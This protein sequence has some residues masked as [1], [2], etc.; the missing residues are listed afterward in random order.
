MTPTGAGA[1]PERDRSQLLTPADL[2][3][4]EAI[5]TADEAWMMMRDLLASGHAAETL[6]GLAE[7]EM[8]EFW[9][10][11]DGL[12]VTLTP[13]GKHRRSVEIRERVGFGR[14][15]AM[16]AGRPVVDRDGNPVMVNTP[17]V[18]PYWNPAGQA[19][20][21]LGSRAVRKRDRR[22]A[23][24]ERVP[25]PAPGPEF[26]IDDVSEK[27]VELFA[28]LFDG[29]PV[30]GVKVVIDKRLKPKAKAKAKRQRS[31]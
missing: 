23:I 5:E 29:T 4:L 27:P 28:R 10:H 17:E 14:K 2:A 26:L 12:A 7:A 18:I 19:W 11:P 15:Q 30:S 3:V 8:I 31:G 25:D 6:V 16:R 9:E 22:L 20:G 24:P 1:M 13:L 21:R